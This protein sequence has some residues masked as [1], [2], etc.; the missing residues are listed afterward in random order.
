MSP[1]S[2][3]LALDSPFSRPVLQSL[4]DAGFPPAALL[5]PNP[6][7]TAPPI[8]LP[9]NEPSTLTLTPHTTSISHLAS[10]HPLP[11]LTLGD[12]RHPDTLAALRT[13][14]PD[15]LITACFPR[16]LPPE[17][18]AIPRLGGLNLHPSLLPAYRGPE[19]LFWQFYF[20]E[21][22]TGITLH[23]M[24]EHADTGDIVFQA[25][26]P[27]PDGVS[28]AQAEMLSAQAGGELLCR[29]LAD[30][31]HLPRTPQPSKTSEVRQPNYAQPSAPGA[32][33]ARYHPRPAASDLV[34]PTSWTARRA[35]NFLCAARDW[36]PFEMVDVQSGQRF[37]VREAVGWEAGSRPVT[38][39]K[40]GKAVIGVR[41]ADGVVDL[42]MCD[43]LD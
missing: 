5:L 28:L 40:T 14:Q 34:V 33:N 21:T 29:A 1:T 18:L 30:P 32:G 37:R 12:L 36:G 17:M 27:F 8:I 23:W 16:L 7:R 6:D 22:R 9:P 19:P 39:P 4:L 35:Y 25:D 42:R 31:E 20:G 3:L 11:L 10:Q 2:L 41:F 15:L 38:P 24:D 13:Y 43:V 26:V